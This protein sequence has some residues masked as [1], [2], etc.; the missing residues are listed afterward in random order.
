MAICPKCG[1][2]FSGFSFGSNPAT[3]CKDC[4][5]PVTG[6]TAIPTNLDASSVLAASGIQP[7][8]PIVTLGLIALNVLVYVGMGL[9]GVSWTNPSVTEAV[10]WGADFGPLT[11]SGEWW[12]VLTSTFVHFGIIHI[13]FNMWCLWS[14]GSSLELFIGQKAFAVT[15]VVSGL[16]ASLVST[17]WNP[18]RVSAGASGAIFGIAGAFVTY[19]YLKKVPVEANFVKQKLKSLAI[20]IGYNLLYGMRGSVDNSAHLGGL[21]SGL[22]LGALVPPMLKRIGGAVPT[23]ESSFLP[24]TDDDLARAE[25]HAK[26]IAWQI[27]FGSAIVLLIAGTWIHAGNLPLANYGKAVAYLEVGHLD[28][29]ADELQRAESMAPESFYSQA[30]LGELR[31]DQGNPSAAIA[32][33]EQ[34]LA[35]YPDTFYIEHNLALAYLGSGRPADALQEITFAAKSETQSPWRAECILAYAAQQTGDSR[36]ANENWRLVTQSNP[37]F[38]EAGEALALSASESIHN[39]AFVIPYSKLVFKSRAWPLYP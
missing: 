10:R 3:E 11:V 33:L 19:L 37:D 15:Y 9:S 6:G 21:I 14:L 2:E 20:F 24:S 1:K 30:M 32:P 29:A 31:L 22:V 35:L 38:R 25:S 5:K 12:R 18:W 26:R 17:A 4:R 16:T 39:A 28:Q 23:G 34:A 36:L 27:P 13:A 7:S 8:T